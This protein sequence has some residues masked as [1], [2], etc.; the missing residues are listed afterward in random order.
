M[1]GGRDGLRN[2]AGTRLAA[3][4]QPWLF[5]VPSDSSRFCCSGAVQPSASSRPARHRSHSTPS[6][7]CW[8]PG[9]PCAASWDCSRTRKAFRP[10][11]SSAKT[12]GAWC[13]RSAGSSKVRWCVSVVGGRTRSWPRSD[14]TSPAGSPAQGQ[15]GSGG[16]RGT[17][18]P[19][20][21]R[22]PAGAGLY[23]WAVPVGFH[24]DSPRGA[25][26][27]YCDRRSQLLPPLPHHA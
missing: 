24:I 27:A 6:G 25:V 13:L 11:V 26:A 17:E 18:R 2:G 7:A 21:H 16:S 1:R 20:S 8:K 9:R 3:R 12:T 19:G 15:T 22:D 5:F 23:G 10:H 4:D 14:P